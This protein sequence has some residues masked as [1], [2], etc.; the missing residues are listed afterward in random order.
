MVP[1]LISR[2][3]RP[4]PVTP[5]AAG[6]LRS[7]LSGQNARMKNW[8]KTSGFAAK[9]QEICVVPGQGR[10][11]ERVLIGYAAD[12]AHWAFAALPRKLPAG[13]YRLDGAAPQASALASNFALGW[14]LGSYSFSRYRKEPRRAAALVWPKGV[15]REAI[16]RAAEA[17]F[18][19]R[20]L[21]NTPA[22][23][24]G[25]AQ[26]AD[27][28]VKLA[29]RFGARATVIAG[30]DLLAQNYP[31]IH[32]VGRASSKGPRGSARDRQPR[33]ADI[34]WGREAA[35]KV[36]LVGKGV[37]FDS[38]GLNLKNE[39]GMKLM[40]KDMGGAA[41]V[42]GLALMIMSA[43]LDVRLRVLIPAVENS[44]SGESMRP[45]DVV[46][47]R[48]G[49]TVEIG[50]TDAEGRLIL[51]D[52]LTE[53]SRENP[54]LL[55]DCAT[56]TG[57]ARAALGPDVPALFCND[58]R[59]AADILRHAARES[60]PLWRLPLWQGYRDGL[61]SAVADLSSIS[62]SPYAGA[63]TAALFLETFVEPRV[64]WAHLDMMAWN[65][66]ARP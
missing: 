62:E 5:L 25:P 15:D 44:V 31:L 7:W 58:D 40:K 57:A 41:H 50:N 37:C 48:K 1:S 60:D 16:V 65:V 26:L 35:P 24:M 34:R 28:A 10:A 19:V 53:A 38:G 30:D 61:E 13:A 17:A 55:V 66:A 36:T 9:P 56:L 51:A 20:D 3:A 46:K 39:A 6:D 12:D 21:I 32:A 11:I 4:V 52:A 49:L 33:L 45:L 22:S 23:D 8:V 47:S 29:K 63:I 2:A 64:P 54:A 18:L 59:L 14:A 42:L 43:K 27:A